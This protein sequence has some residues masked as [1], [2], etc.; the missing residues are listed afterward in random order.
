MWKRHIISIHVLYIACPIYW[1]TIAST[2]SYFLG[3]NLYTLVRSYLEPKFYLRTEYSKL[4]SRTSEV[5][6]GRTAP[7]RAP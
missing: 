1:I 5:L 2:R 4:M 7:V 3:H 6:G